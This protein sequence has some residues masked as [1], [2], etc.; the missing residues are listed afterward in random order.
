MIHRNHNT[1]QIIVQPFQV[2]N[3][4]GFVQARYSTQLSN[5]ALSS[6]FGRRLPDFS[7]LELLAGETLGEELEQKV[8][9]SIQQG[10]GIFL[11]VIPRVEIKTSHTIDGFLVTTTVPPTTTA[12]SEGSGNFENS[13]IE[14]FPLI[15]THS[16]INGK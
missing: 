16:E 15:P 10:D 14:L 11:D 4:G 3:Q 1:R 9:F 12:S 13:G 6:S 8:D 2:L 5:S 7:N